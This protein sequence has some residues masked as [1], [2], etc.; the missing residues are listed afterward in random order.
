MPDRKQ[1]MEQVYAAFNR[2]DVAGTL[3][4][5]T[6]DVS[7]PKASEGGRVVGKD[8]IRAYWARQWEEFDPHVEPLAV[9]E[10]EDGRVQVQVHQV[11][12][13]LQGD[14]LADG[15]VLHV[16]TMRD[17]MIVAM[18]LRGEEAAGAGPAAAFSHRS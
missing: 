9:T 1:V 15:E 14:V 16:Y 13:N 6:E 17:G 8:A 4:W 5:M 11:V 12:R 10:D 3:A 18:E 7:W 2:R